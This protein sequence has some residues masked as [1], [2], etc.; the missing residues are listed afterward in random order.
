MTLV[1]YVVRR[2]PQRQKHN[3]KGKGRI[4][5][6]TNEVN[7]SEHE[8]MIDLAVFDPFSCNVLPTHVGQ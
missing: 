4:K 2:K 5:K 7:M 6:N 3:T 1:Y 8:C